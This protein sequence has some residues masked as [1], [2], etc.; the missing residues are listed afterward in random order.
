MK[1][2][3]AHP[4]R[5]RGAGAGYAAHQLAERTGQ[6]GRRADQGTAEG[7]APV[8]GEELLQPGPLADVPPGGR[9]Y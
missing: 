6:R 3:H 5:A 2:F 9:P 1:L 7:A 4:L 8:V